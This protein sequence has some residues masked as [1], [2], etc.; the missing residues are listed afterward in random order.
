MKIERLLLIAALF[1]PLTMFAQGPPPGGP[2]GPGPHGMEPHAGR[3]GHGMMG[4]WWKN[5]ELAQQLQLSDQQK[6]QLDK[7]FYDHRMKLID[8]QA[9]L[10]KQDLKLQTMLDEDTP[11]ESQVSTQVDQELAAKSKL[12]REFTMMN[13][14]LRTVLTVEQWR[15]LKD[16]RNHHGPEGFEHSR[17]DRQQ[18]DSRAHM[19]GEHAPP[20]PN[21]DQGPPPA[22]NTNPPAAP[23][24]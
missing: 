6:Q 10:E 9:D 2:G 19:R 12:E 22:S 23:N 1:L 11:N 24:Q 20:P 18:R 16:M 4:E 13:L 7:V 8:L 5:S 21:D 3:D 17:D 14:N 15:K